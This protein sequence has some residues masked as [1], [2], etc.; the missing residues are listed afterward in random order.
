MPLH[1]RTRTHARARSRTCRRASARAPRGR[2]FGCCCCDQYR[3]MLSYSACVLLCMVTWYRYAEMRAPP[4]L[5][6]VQQVRCCAWYA[7]AAGGLISHSRAHG[8]GQE[9]YGVHGF[10]Q[11][12]TG[13]LACI[14]IRYRLYGVRRN[15]GIATK[16]PRAKSCQQALPQRKRKEKLEAAVIAEHVWRHFWPRAT[17]S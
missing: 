5:F 6:S 9:C 16:H 11:P 15:N 2:G 10:W 1:S 3:E 4:A 12:Q 13:H 17:T 8:G 14:H 7:G